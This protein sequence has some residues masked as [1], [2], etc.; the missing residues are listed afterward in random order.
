MA[1]R[2]LSDEEARRIGTALKNAREQLGWSRQ[3]LADRAGTSNTN[4]HRMEGGGRGGLSLSMVFK[5]VEVMGCSWRDVLG[6]EPG[7]DG[8]EPVEYWSGYR[9]G[10]SDG[11]AALSDLMRKQGIGT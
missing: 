11:H 6:P 7:T 1:P 10:I 3:E 2:T 8:A 5:M 9:A 4:I